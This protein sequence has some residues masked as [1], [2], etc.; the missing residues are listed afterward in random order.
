MMMQITISIIVPVYNVEQYITKCVQSLLDQTHENFEA[1]FVD[2][3]STDHSIEIAKRLVRNDARFIFLEKKNGGQAS[4][5]NLGLDHVS[6]NY[7]AFVD[8]DDYIQSD[9]LEKMLTAFDE[10]KSLDIVMCGYQQ[11]DNAENTL[12]KIMPN[13]QKYYEHNDILFRQE[14]ID[15]SVCNK[16]YTRSVWDNFRF[17]EGIIY[18]DK[19]ILPRLC[20]QKNISVIQ[21]YLYYYVHRQGST[22][23]SYRLQKSLTSMLFVYR[24]FYQFLESAHVENE[25][26]DYY[27]EAYIKYCFYQHLYMILAHS[28]QYQLDCQYLIT[29]IDTKIVSLNNVRKYYGIASKQFMTFMLFKISPVLMK[30]VLN[31]K[32]GLQ[33]LLKRSR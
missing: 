8:S 4:A 2:D 10:D 29:N 31:L 15:Y 12:W 20:Y 14:Y 22:M 13:P 17:I 5:R 21:E 3:G 7:I 32:L 6:G 24:S 19:E 28:P 11:V 23:N 16:M 18:E 26:Q 30:N 25:Y 1:I 9:F 27:Q 33:R